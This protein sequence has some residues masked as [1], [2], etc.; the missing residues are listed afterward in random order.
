MKLWIKSTIVILCIIVS[1]LF[2]TTVHGWF[3]INKQVTITLTNITEPYWIDIL[4]EKDEAPLYSTLELLT[5]LP[6]DYQSN[7]Y[8]DMM[9]GFQSEDG[10]VSFRLYAGEDYQFDKIETNKYRFDYFFQGSIVY[11][12]AIIYPDG[13]LH[14]S[15]PFTQSKN[16]LWVD[17]DL[18]TLSVNEYDSPGIILEFTPFPPRN[19]T[20]I[21]PVGIFI[22]ASLGNF[23]FFLFG[24]RRKKNYLWVSLRNVIITIA[25]LGLIYLN[26]QTSYAPFPFMVMFLLPTLMFIE[27]FIMA[28][29]IKEL[30]P[31]K[32][33]Y[34]ILFSN[35]IIFYTSFL[36]HNFYLSY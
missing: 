12:I 34:Y 1:T 7:T 17:Y 31:K 16:G 35:I 14:V 2:V 21:I 20:W 26:T 15:E 27:M 32:A 24:Y 25:A 6:A 3:T 29:K 28:G 36:L 4:I 19:R 30:H 22:I 9:N 33:M 5:L 13:T 11:K 18:S 23:I 10:F 8:K